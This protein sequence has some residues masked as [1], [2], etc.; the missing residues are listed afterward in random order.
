MSQLIQASMN[1][2]KLQQDQVAS[3]ESMRQ[4]YFLMEEATDK[5]DFLL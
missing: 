1:V 2:K 3:I 5:H 4:Q